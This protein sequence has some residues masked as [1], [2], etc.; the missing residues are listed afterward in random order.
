MKIYKI[1]LFAGFWLLFFS[2]FGHS[3]FDKVREIKGLSVQQSPLSDDKTDPIKRN[4][5]D[6]SEFDLEENDYAND[7]VYD[8]DLVP[9]ISDNH[10]SSSLF[11]VHNFQNLVQYNSTSLFHFLRTSRSYLNVFRI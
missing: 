6:F 3:T 2:V 4:S 1:I 11:I 9:L 7:F 10:P 8:F 5:L